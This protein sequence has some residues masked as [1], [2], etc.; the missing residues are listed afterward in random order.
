MQGCHGRARL[1]GRGRQ[2][3][4]AGV[5]RGWG[6]GVG[7]RGGAQGWIGVSASRATRSGSGVPVVAGLHSGASRCG[8]YL[9]AAGRACALTDA[10]RRGAECG[11]M[12]GAEGRRRQAW[13]GLEFDSTCAATPARWQAHL[14]QGSPSRQRLSKGL[15]THSFACHEGIPSSILTGFSTMCSPKQLRVEDSEGGHGDCRRSRPPHF[16]S[17][18]SSFIPRAIFFTLSNYEYRY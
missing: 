18:R 8:S 9:R 7:P 17:R 4:S 3:T 13:L 2:W 1:S 15:C 6:A 16:G 5:A 11:R 12:V 10:T 14:D